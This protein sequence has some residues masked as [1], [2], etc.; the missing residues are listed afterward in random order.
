MK[1]ENVF[2]ELNGEKGGEIAEG[3]VGGGTGMICHEFKCGT[4][5]SSR[6]VK[7]DGREYRICRGRR[8][9]R[10]LEHFDDAGNLCLDNF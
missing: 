4:G 1:T 10:H 3:N 5:T 2:D 7:I 6:V 8:R 9:E